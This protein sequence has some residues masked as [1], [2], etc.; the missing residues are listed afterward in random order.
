MRALSQYLA[1]ALL[2]AFATVAQAALITGKQ[3]EDYFARYVATGRGNTEFHVNTQGY[4]GLAS[5]RGS[6][7]GTFTCGVFGLGVKNDDELE[8]RAKLIHEFTHC[9]VSPY[10]GNGQSG[11]PD[12]L[13]GLVARD[14]HILTGE[15]IAD[16]RALIEVWRR[17]RLAAMQAL[18]KTMLAR[19]ARASDVGHG[20][21]RALEMTLREME[22]H[23]G[24]T[25][26]DDNAF[27][28][29]LFIGQTAAN[30]T[31]RTLLRE[32]GHGD[33]FQSPLLIEAEKEISTGVLLAYDAFLH[34]AHR[35]NMLTIHTGDEK[36]AGENYHVFV[37]ED[38][39]IRTE[40]AMGTEGARGLQPLKDLMASSDAPEHRLA[41]LLLS[42]FGQLG[43]RQ[44]LIARGHF[45]R[46]ANGLGKD[47]P[48]K[49]ERVLAIIAETIAT[50][51]KTDG[52]NE[53]FNTA[54]KKLILEF[55]Q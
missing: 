1:L 49:R 37:G 48:E 4:F 25:M 55:E 42:K 8:Q 7:D 30:E 19:R 39:S 22:Q 14:L 29:A 44:I 41:L 28:L 50:T 32:N 5:I 20:T 15:S 33:V 40:A 47:S 17:D 54:A 35:N 21:T 18:T 3:V 23:P 52:L 10:M 24:R 45:E 26:T 43:E 16:A 13:A 31:L 53:F 12:T 51:P 46:W 6:G 36:N 34:G 9:L 27:L 11:E 38:G 2:A